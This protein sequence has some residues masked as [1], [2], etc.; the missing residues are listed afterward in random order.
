MKNKNEE[1]KYN[2]LLLNQIA[3]TVNDIIL[4]QKLLQKT[5]N[6]YKYFITLT[7]TEIGKFLTNNPDIHSIFNSYYSNL[8][9]E[10]TKTKKEYFERVLPKYNNLNNSCN[11]MIFNESLLN[12]CISDKFLLKY[13]LIQGNNTIVCLKKSISSTKKYNLF[14]EPKRENLTEMKESNDFIVKENYF[15]NS[16]LLFLCKKY[17]KF[18][19]YCREKEKMKKKLKDVLENNRNQINMQQP[20]INNNENG[21]NNNQNIIVDENI[22]NNEINEENNS[23]FFNRNTLTESNNR[24]IYQ[25]YNPVFYPSLENTDDEEAIDEKS[26]LKKNIRDDNNIS[27]FYNKTNDIPIIL[28]SNKKKPNAAL[29]TS[30]SKINSDINKNIIQEFPIIDV[31][32]DPYMNENENEEFLNIE[33]DVNFVSNIKP[34]KNINIDYKNDIKNKIPKLNFIQISYNS[35]RNMKEIDVYSLQRRRHKVRDNIN[36]LKEK[37]REIKKLEQA[38]NLN[39]M[40]IK[41]L[42]NSITNLYEIYKTFKYVK[43]QTSF[44][45]NSPNFTKKNIFEVAAEEIKKIRDHSK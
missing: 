40:K 13:S 34:Y 44:Y 19:N 42:E 45:E 8:K 35:E 28:N 9:S 29:F 20:R 6:I 43:K 36:E 33:D 26:P 24:K 12:K 7:K 37:K 4:K 18:V 31:L 23:E 17:N 22:N 32:F 25:S 15:T 38:I 16:N 1:N 5:I 39:K 10:I 21:N 2:L 41:S 3:E 11:D 30:K 27:A 14:R